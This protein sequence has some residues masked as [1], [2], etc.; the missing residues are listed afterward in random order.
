M[1]TMRMAMDSL[2]VE[3]AVMSPEAFA[4]H[5]RAAGCF[6]FVTDSDSDWPSED[7]IRAQW[8]Q[9]GMG[10]LSDEFFGLLG[11]MRSRVM[12]RESWATRRSAFVHFYT[13]AES[14]GLNSN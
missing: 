9:W 13:L 1:P 3:G 12:S 6:V 5:V 4:E 2:L 8:T 10:H 11:E 14:G 7:Q